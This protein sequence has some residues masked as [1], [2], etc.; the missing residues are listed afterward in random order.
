MP[1]V[2]R[3]DEDAAK[4]LFDRAQ[5][6]YRL[7]KYDEAIPDY[8]AAYQAMAAPA[9]LFNIAQAQRMQYSID[10]KVFRLHKALALYKSYLRESRKAPNRQMVE[11]LIDEL[12]QL[13]SDL[14]RQG[15][16]QDKPGQLLLRGS[17]GAQVWLDGERSGVLPLRKN[18]DPGTHIL[19]VE[20]A[21]FVPWEST[22]RVSA[23]GQLDVPVVLA[24]A[25]EEGRQ[26]AAATNSAAPVYRTW[27]FWTITAA[28]VAG[29]VGTSVY[30]ATR[31]DDAPTLTTIDL[32]N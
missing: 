32:R 16:V 2:G 1:A 25:P 7:G 17:A 28:A 18:V 6:A 23:G 15:A 3:A 27:W 26:A 8:E 20:A 12:K 10:N 22:V 9:F 4:R 13:L 30:F 11:R 29:A 14:Q 31:S 19:R 21:G 5:T 24:K